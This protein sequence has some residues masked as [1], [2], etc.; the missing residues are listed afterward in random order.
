[1][2]HT[3]AEKILAAKSGLR[4]VS[5]GELVTARPDRVMSHDN[6]GLVIR[7][8]RSIGAEKV[9]DPSKI[10]IPL[11]HRA[12]AESEQ[13]ATAHKSIR[14]F[15][16]EQG[17]ESFY[18]IREGICHQVMIENGHVAPGEL[19]LGTDSH[20]TSYGCLGSASSGIGATEMAAVWATGELWLRVPDTIRIE[21]NGRFKPNVTPKDLVLFILGKLGARGADYKS[22]EYYGS[23]ISN[24]PVSGRFTITNM[25]MEMGAKFGIIPFDEETAI[26]LKGRVQYDYTPVSADPDA[27]YSQ[28]YE[29][30]ISDLTPQIAMPHR[31]DNVVPLSEAAGIEINQ[32]VIGSCTNGR[33]DDLQIVADILA[34]KKV[35]KKIRLL[36]I[37]GSRSI[38]IQAIKNGIL[39]TLSEAGAVILNPGCGP[40]LGAHQGILA[41]GERCLATTNRNFKGRMGSTEAEVYLASPVVA[42]HTALTGEIPDRI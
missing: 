18:D 14:E 3:I 17:I 4:S 41:P 21:V 11:D 37:P 40:C 15:V 12:P 29:F 10:I 13:T 16:E 28:R 6:A 35:T 30:D 38:Y 20:T 27:Q 31:V 32:V 2:P 25:T 19:I 22:V 26:Y 5:P 1:M 36:V 23:V 42:A 33:I 7:H 9:F 39:E 24:M 8:F 34:S